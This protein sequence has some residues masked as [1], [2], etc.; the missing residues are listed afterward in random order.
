MYFI[1]V[2]TIKDDMVDSRRCVGYVDSLEEAKNIIKDNVCDIFEYVYKYAV[3]ENVPSGIYQYDMNP[4]W[5][6]CHY[7]TDEITE[8]EN[9]LK[10]QVGF[11]IG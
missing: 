5:F 7:D 9:P 2:L 3:I 11:G 1:T 10:N 8:C 4:I 6:E